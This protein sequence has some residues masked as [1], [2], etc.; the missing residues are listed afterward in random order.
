MATNSK[1]KKLLEEFPK[2]YSE[3][4]GIDLESRKP[5]E[6][7]KWFLASILFGA[8]ISETIAKNTY[9]TFV[10]HKI[11]TPQEIQDASWYEMIDIMGEGGYVRYDGKTTDTLKNISKKLLDEYDGNLNN[12]YEIAENS[13]DIEEK[14]QEFKGIGAITI[15]IFLRELRVVWPRADPRLSKFVKLAMKNLGIDLKKFNKRTEKF[16]HIESALLRLG[17]DYCNKKKCH[18]CKMKKFCKK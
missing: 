11:L 18:V 6:I 17:K 7:F 3:E 5:K 10:K 14:L 9:K 16:I 1:I 2:T 15:N 4:L 12:L 13:E 8:R